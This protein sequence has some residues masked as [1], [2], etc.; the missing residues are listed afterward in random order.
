VLARFASALLSLTVC[1]C[2]SLPRQ[3]VERAL[4]IDARKALHG[5]SRLGWTVDRVEIAEAADQAAPSMCRASP[6]HR[7]A[8]LR[9]IEEQIG[10]A[11]GPA[12]QQYKSGVELDDLDDVIDL[13]R[14]RAL[15]Q[16]AELHMPDDCAF[17]VKPSESFRGLHATTQR[18]VLIAES[19]GVGSLLLSGRRVQAGAGGGV[20]V[21][22][23]YGIST[24]LQLAIGLESGGDAV[25]V[26]E[27]R[28]S[29]APAGAFRFGVPAFLR[30]IDLD[31]IYDL[32]L[33]A[34]TRLSERKLTPWGARIAIAGGVS[35][36][37]RL[38]FMPALQLSVGYEIY[39]AQDS[40]KAQHVLS[41]GTRVG[42]DW[43]P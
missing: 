39:P 15:L 20:R 4:Y 19:A 33:A 13:E 35:G 30:L 11:G 6:A 9:W 29:L 1:S 36:L 18:L 31:R 10:A 14:T 34:V 7:A 43:D 41:L 17:W 2:I 26:Q 37:R 21:F 42:I 27:E 16:Q 32:E 23:S 8:V 28:G 24:Y 38:G 40:M 25:L 3:P 22:G 5:E 12:E